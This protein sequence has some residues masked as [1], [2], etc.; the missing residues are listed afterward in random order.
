[1]SAPPLPPLRILHCLSS[2]PGEDRAPRLA[3]LI[4]GLGSDAAHSL[5]GDAAAVAAIRAHLAPGC[6]VSTP[7]SFPSLAGKP[8]PGRLV[9]LA[10]AMQPYD[11]VCTYNWGAI[12]AA[13]AHGVF[14]KSLT[15]PPL[16]H[17]ED[18]F[19]AIEAEGLRTTR[20]L[21]RRAALRHAHALVVPSLLIARIAQQA[22]QQPANKVVHIP[23]GIDTAAFAATPDPHAIRVIKRPGERWVGTVASLDPASQLPLL[24]EAM[25][26]LPEEWH[27]VIVGEG[28][29]RDAIRAE[30]AARELSHRVHLAGAMAEPARVMGLFDIYALA[31]PGEPHSLTV[32]QAMAAGL[33][34]AAPDIGD[35]RAMVAEPNRPFMAVP[36]KAVALGQMLADLA[37]DG[38]LRAAIGAANRARASTEYAADRMMAHYRAL[39]WQA[40]GR[41]A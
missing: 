9:T 21:Y 26:A 22:W 33:P 31:A 23:P 34:V 13:M 15:L 3:T 30:A 5:V 7:A 27:L 1:M 10:E 4:A 2:L 25:C 36:G 35:I 18:A 28:P 19:D 16:I 17:H 6:K 20:N 14:A 38:A 11:L 12:D 39:Y 32:V 29:E 37:E 41:A 40:V 24:V 8:T